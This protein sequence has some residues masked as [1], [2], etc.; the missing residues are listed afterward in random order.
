M[1]RGTLLGTSNIVTA[2]ASAWITLMPKTAQNHRRMASLSS[3]GSTHNIQAVMGNTSSTSEGR[4]PEKDGSVGL[5]QTLETSLE[6]LRAL[7]ICR[8][9]VRPLFEPYTIECGH[10]FCYGC[11]SRWFER[12]RTK[13]TCPDCRAETTRAPAPAYL[14]RNFILHCT[15]FQESCSYI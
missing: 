9:C 11:L 5:L 4:H 8:V 7:I 13:K 12:D 15:T 3:T 1:L 6:D 2:S 14:V 10:T